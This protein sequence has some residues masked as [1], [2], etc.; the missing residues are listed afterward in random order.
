[1]EYVLRTIFH[2]INEGAKEIL[3]DLMFSLKMFT[4]FLMQQVIFYFF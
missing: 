3:I 1:M 2:R 4:F